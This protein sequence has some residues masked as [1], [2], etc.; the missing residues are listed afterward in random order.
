MEGKG[1]QGANRKR[2]RGT[3]NPLSSAALGPSQTLRERRCP[4]DSLC[5]GAV[6]GF[7]KWAILSPLKREKM[8][9]WPV[10]V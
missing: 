4:H 8:S 5:Q 6:K 10:N 2:D 1:R 9:R 7:S 3:Q